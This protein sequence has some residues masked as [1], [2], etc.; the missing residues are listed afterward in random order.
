MQTL[1]A[2]SAEV[3]HNGK[4]QPVVLGS[5]KSIRKYQIKVQYFELNMTRSEARGYIEKGMVS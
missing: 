2:R 4:K 3:E 5:R 1:T